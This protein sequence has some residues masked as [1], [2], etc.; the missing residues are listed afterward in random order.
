MKKKNYLLSLLAAG[1]LSVPAYS[2]T[3]PFPAGRIA[4]SFD[5]NFVYDIDT[6]SVRSEDA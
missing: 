1:M 3:F 5:G 4:L 6:L 2:Q